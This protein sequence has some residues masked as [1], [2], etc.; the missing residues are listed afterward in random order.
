MRHV[1]VFLRRFVVAAFS[2]IAITAGLAVLFW[3]LMGGWVAS[4]VS[5]LANQHVF[6]DRLTRLHVG[7]VTGS[8]FSNIIFE[9]VHLE[10][11]IGG[12]WRSAVFAKQVEAR[13]D[14]A[15]L[16]RGRS[17]LREIKVWQPL[18]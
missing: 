4:R 12:E 16:A 7:R 14:V 18:I 8:V 5:S 15:A 1:L 17:E 2:G 3:V 6:Q 11:Q 9:D 10:R 13:Y